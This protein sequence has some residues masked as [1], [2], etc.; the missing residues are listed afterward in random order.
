[1]AMEPTASVVHEHYSKEDASKAVV[2]ARSALSWETKRTIHTQEVISI[3]VYCDVL[4]TIIMPLTIK[5]QR[6]IFRYSSDV[7]SKWLK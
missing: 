6:V 3:V 1:M 7:L 2:H 4:I 5:L